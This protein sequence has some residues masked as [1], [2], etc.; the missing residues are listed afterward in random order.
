MATTTHQSGRHIALGEIRV[1]E[2]V[3]ALDPGHVTALAG[4]IKL[5]DGWARNLSVLGL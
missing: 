3:R 1:A 5:L 2:N 4:S